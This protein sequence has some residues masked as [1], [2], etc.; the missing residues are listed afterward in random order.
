MKMHVSHANVCALTGLQI[1]EG[2]YM[3]LKK[4]ETTAIVEEYRNG[5]KSRIQATINDLCKSK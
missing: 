2:S 4:K 1:S 3:T 5:I